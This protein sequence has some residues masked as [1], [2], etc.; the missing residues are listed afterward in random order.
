MVGKNNYYFFNDW[1]VRV[2]DVI[3]F[4]YIIIYTFIRVVIEKSI[5][6]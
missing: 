3:L 2:I 1:I 4:G 5:R 6:N